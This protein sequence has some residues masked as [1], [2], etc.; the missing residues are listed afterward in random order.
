MSEVF[1]SSIP[2][3]VCDAMSSNKIYVKGTM[4]SRKVTG[5]IMN[6]EYGRFPLRILVPN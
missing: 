3:F 5:L 4:D 6:T 1:I 2:G